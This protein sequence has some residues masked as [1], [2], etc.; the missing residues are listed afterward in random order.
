MTEEGTFLNVENLLK[1]TT[2][3]LLGGDSSMVPD[4]AFVVLFNEIARLTANTVGVAKIAT[5]SYAGTDKYGQSNPNSLTFDFA[6]KVIAIVG[7][8]QSSASFVDLF[9]GNAGEAWI[10]HTGLLTTSYVQGAGFGK[11]S[12][13]KKS[14]DGKTVYWYGTSAAN[15]YNYAMYGTVYHWIAIG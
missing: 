8:I 2:A 11:D 5:G 3:A 4:E 7:Y 13:A 12:Y 15:Q 6:P 14:S 9:S 10:I 1:D